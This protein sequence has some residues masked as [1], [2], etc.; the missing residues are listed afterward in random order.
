[1]S[2]KNQNI[3]VTKKEFYLAITSILTLLCCVVIAGVSGNK[4]YSLILVIIMGVCQLIYM[5]RYRNSPIF[6]KKQQ[7]VTEN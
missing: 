1:M 7:S 6:D 3:Y 5:R 2:D 4:F